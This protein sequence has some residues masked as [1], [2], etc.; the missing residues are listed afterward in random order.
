M[1]LKITGHTVKRSFEEYFGEASCVADRTEAGDWWQ[2]WQRGI[3]HF[4]GG[5]R[6]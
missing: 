5:A 1:M 4:V 6:R 2:R 3:I